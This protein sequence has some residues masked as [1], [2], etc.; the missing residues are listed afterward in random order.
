MST[1]SEG[2]QNCLDKFANYYLKILF[3]LKKAFC[4]LL[5][6]SEIAVEKFPPQPINRPKYLYSLTL[7]AFDHTVKPVLLYSSEVWGMFNMTSVLNSRKVKITLSMTYIMIIAFC[8]LLT[9][10][11]IAVEKFPPQ[12]INRPKYLYSLTHIN[13]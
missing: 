9:R 6:R 13:L 10:S 8:P 12:P 3:T 4:P 7:K 11:E 5:T 1:K 2:L